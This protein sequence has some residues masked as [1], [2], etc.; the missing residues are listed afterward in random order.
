MSYNIK[1]QKVKHLYQSAANRGMNSL[2]WYSKDDSK[3]SLPSGIYF[4]RLK[5]EGHCSVR[6]ILLLK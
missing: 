5:S 4:I 3:K 6:K 2:D 1:G